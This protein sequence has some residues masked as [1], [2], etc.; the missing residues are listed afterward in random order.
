MSKREWRCRSRTCAVP[1]GAVLGRLWVDRE[2][3]V[4]EPGVAIGAVYLDSGRV[5]VVCPAC[6][7]VRDFRGLAVRR[8]GRVTR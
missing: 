4:L 2:G 6:G 3:L 5:E 7:V 8:S 1:G